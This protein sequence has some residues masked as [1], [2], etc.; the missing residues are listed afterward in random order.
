MK[1]KVYYKPRRNGDCSKYLQKKIT[2]KKI[3]IE[4]TRKASSSP[5]IINIAGAIIIPNI[6]R[7][8]LH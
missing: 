4:N 6:C 3:I 5:A 1:N 8:T 2:L 7:K